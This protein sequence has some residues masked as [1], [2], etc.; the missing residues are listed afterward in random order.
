MFGGLG[1]K[2]GLLKQM[3]QM[4]GKMKEMRAALESSTYEGEAGGGAVSATINGKMALVGLKISPDT[5]GSG[6]V[7]ML[8]DLIKAAVTAGQR[9]AAE[10]IKEKMR[11]LTGGLNVPGLSDMIDEAG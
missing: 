7:E 4:Q 3:M 10:G 8:E 11:E 6:D 2:A 9:K 5:A 1:E